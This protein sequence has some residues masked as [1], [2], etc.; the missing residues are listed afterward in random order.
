M[1][2]PYTDLRSGM[3]AREWDAAREVWG[4]LKRRPLPAPRACQSCGQLTSRI[5]IGALCEKVKQPG[6]VEQASKDM[7]PGSIG[8]RLHP[9]HWE[10]VSWCDGCERARNIQQ[11]RAIVGN[12][13]VYEHV[14]EAAA[15]F[16]RERNAA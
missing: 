12:P 1:T 9:T 8:Y 5:A 14:R 2:A 6:E 7:S 3:L 13:A 4:A 16:L 11:A 15:Q 10:T